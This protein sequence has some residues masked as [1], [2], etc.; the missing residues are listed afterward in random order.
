MNN[1]WSDNLRDRMKGFQ[2]DEPEDLWN[3]LN[4]QLKEQNRKQKTNW[5]IFRLAVPAAAAVIAGFV[6]Y[7]TDPNHTDNIENKNITQEQTNNN[8]TLQNIK[9]EQELIPSSRSKTKHVKFT[10]SNN[11]NLSDKQTTA[12][13]NKSPEKSDDQPQQG[14]KETAITK[15]ALPEKKEQERKTIRIN[16]E[17]YRNIEKRLLA[18]EISHKKR[19]KQWQLALAANQGISNAN[20]H[21]SGFG[22]IN[23]GYIKTDAANN[24]WG[25]SYF[26]YIVLYNKN[27]M[28]KTSVKHLQPITTGLTLQYRINDFWSIESGLT[29]TLLV[30]KLQS[31]GADHYYKSHQSL[32]LIGIPI[33]AGFTFWQNKQF[34]TYAKAGI[35]FEKCVSGN[36]KT[37]YFKNKEVVSREKNSL[38]IDPL[39]Y[40]LTAAVG[41]Q[42]NFAGQCGLYAEPGIG[43]HIPPHTEIQTIYQEKP[44]NFNLEIGLRFTFNNK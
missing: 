21:Y 38:K 30:S 42:W 13:E 31:G 10:A 20:I 15:D 5:K 41:I 9:T 2:V 1:K 11:I 3:D 19:N 23:K 28:P 34:N 35:L 18:T 40:T 29:Y 25:E 44:V 33:R 26:N 24:N 6:L 7:W 36:L 37:E 39:L 43:Y 17:T 14:N 16:P 22:D 32:H 27:T 12:A 4:K 8:T